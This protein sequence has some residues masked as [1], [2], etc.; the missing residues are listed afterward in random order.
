MKIN[1]CGMMDPA[2]ATQIGLV[3]LPAILEVE[4]IAPSF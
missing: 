4:R 1:S 3:V 2:L